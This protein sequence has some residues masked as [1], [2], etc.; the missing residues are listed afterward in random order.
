MTAYE[1]PVIGIAE[2]RDVLGGHFESTIEHIEQMQGGN[3]S[4]VYSFVHQ[5]QPFVVKFSDLGD[6]YGTERYVSKLLSGQGIPFPRVLGEGDAGKLKY[7]IL[8]RIEGSILADCNTERQIAL[9]PELIQLLTR[10][11]HL[12]VSNTNGYGWIK[13]DGSGT[14]PSWRDYLIDFFAEDQQ[15]NFWEGWYDLF[16][17]SCLERDVFE[18]CYSRLIEYSAYNEPHRHFIHGDYSPWNILTNGQRITGIIDGN[19]AYG[20]FLVDVATLE[21]MMRGWGHDIVRYYQD[22]QEREGFVI[23]NFKE[24][25]I[26]ARYLKGIDGLRFFA[27][28]GWTDA[29]VNTRD[30]LLGLTN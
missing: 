18:E 20:D 28:M 15:G 2:L 25:M 1:K 9:M 3:L 23:P 14:Y 17:T 21:M 30:F 16:R 22:N 12:Q 7:I 19:F 8:E 29:Y 5:G 10:I 26:G 24:R 6:A 4:R 13:P 11:N 27:K